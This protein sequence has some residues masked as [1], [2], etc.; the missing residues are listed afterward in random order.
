MHYYQFNIKDYKADTK[1]LYL[2]EYGALRILL[3][4]YYLDEKIF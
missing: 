3:D 2:I 4:Y 1:H